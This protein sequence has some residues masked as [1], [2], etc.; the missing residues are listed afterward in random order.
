MKNLLNTK[1]TA[2][3]ELLGNGKIY[4]IPDFQRDY[5][6]GEDHWEDLWLD[7]INLIEENIPHY[8]GTL[9]LQTTDEDDK[10]II[11]D[12]QQRIT[13]LS[14]LAIA[15]IGFL[16]NL[17]DKKI[18]PAKN[19]ERIEIFKN[20]FIGKKAASSLFYTSKLSLNE[21]NDSF[22]QSRILLIKK[23]V[24][25]SKLRD[26]EKSL[27]DSYKYFYKKL[28]ER[29]S[30]DDGTQI[31]NFLENIVAKKLIFIQIT[32]D[33]D[34]NAYTVFETLNA[35]GVELITT[36]LLKNYLFSLAAKEAE[37]NIL[38]EDWKIII[39][40]VGLKKFPTFL[41]YYLNAKRALVR[42]ERLFKEIKKDIN[43]GAKV[44]ELLDD[45]KETA[46]LYNALLFPNDDFW[47]EHPD[48]RDIRKSLEELKLFG[49]TQPIPLLFSL[50]KKSPERFVKTLQMCSVIAFRYN[51]IGK[52]NPNEMERVYNN[53]A[54]KI[55]NGEINSIKSIYKSISLIYV[56]DEDFGN[57]FSTKTISTNGKN[58]KLVKYILTKIENQMSGKT[59]T[60]ND[61]AFTIEHIL[62]ENFNEHWNANF[63][64]E[65]EN[66]IYRLGNYT[67][68]EDKKNKK[69]ADKNFESKKSIYK[70]SQFKLSKE[71]LLFDDWN[72]STLNKYQKKLAK[73]AKT[74]WKITKR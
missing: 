69:C 56:N 66:F 48:K 9:V 25:Y 57:I 30:K 39:D 63:D 12:G 47:E 49:V 34:L 2:L 3:N 52:L 54:R 21:N 19:K 50:Y 24:N 27:Y 7:I 45:L 5:S 14:I 11:V 1:D 42:K 28:S 70:T 65:A 73:I 60:F 62:P 10:F 51:V 38:K 46:Y 58:R 35:R 67:F 64:N 44:F 41:R 4:K 36:D 22:Y 17:I 23:P 8:M 6:W 16:Q 74:V 15:V 13:T 31:S 40:T 53:V 68:L 55:Y 33:D 71:C 26:S 32:V 43:T 20:M 59:H 37:L 29:F 61:A 18:E 72:I